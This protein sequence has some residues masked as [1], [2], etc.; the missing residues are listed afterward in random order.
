MNT[1][2]TKHL[3][4]SALSELLPYFYFSIIS[5]AVIDYLL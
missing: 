1:L 4:L 5:K 2:F 3:T